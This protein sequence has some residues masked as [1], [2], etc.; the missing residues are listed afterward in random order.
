MRKA[1]LMRFATLLAA[2][3]ALVSGAFRRDFIWP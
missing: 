1:T 2:L 3:G